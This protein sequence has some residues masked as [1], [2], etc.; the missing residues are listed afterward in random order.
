[1]FDTQIVLLKEI[2]EKGDFEKIG[3]WQKSMKNFQGGIERD[4]SKTH[5]SSVHCMGSRSILKDPPTYK[6]VGVNQLSIACDGKLN[7]V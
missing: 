6:F 2:F 4:S 7:A 1:M 5:L 3:R